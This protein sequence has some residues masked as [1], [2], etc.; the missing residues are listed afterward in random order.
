MRTNKHTH[1]HTHHAR[2]HML[3]RK[4]IHTKTE[5]ISKKNAT[6]TYTNMNGHVIVRWCARY[7]KRMP[8]VRGK[9]GNIDKHKLA[10]FVE[11]ISLAHL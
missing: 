10:R 6:V 11:E 7:G 1:M 4:E 9:I 8:F 2:E 5:T 3:E